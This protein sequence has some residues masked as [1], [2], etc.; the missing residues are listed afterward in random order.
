MKINDSLI[1]NRYKS[2]KKIIFS[3][4]QGKEDAKATSNKLPKVKLHEVMN[5]LND[6]KI[7]RINNPK[8]GVILKELI[9]DSPIRVLRNEKF[10]RFKLSM[11]TKCSSKKGIQISATKSKTKVDKLKN[12]RDL[13][14]KKDEV[15]ADNLNDALLEVTEEDDTFNLN[16]DTLGTLFSQDLDNILSV[17]MSECSF[18]SEEADK[19]K[20]KTKVVKIVS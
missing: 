13:Q 12:K 16:N 6:N 3:E 11:S 15:I 14:V 1:N 19:D 20:K 7:L 5:K 2:N 8:K 18:L 10:P 17:S 9:Q 4:E